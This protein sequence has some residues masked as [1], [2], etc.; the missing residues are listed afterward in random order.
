LC[1]EQSEEYRSSKFIVLSRVISHIS[2]GALLDSLLKEV[3][4]PSIYEQ[5]TSVTE[6]ASGKTKPLREYGRAVLEISLGLQC[7]GLIAKQKGRSFRRYLIHH[8]VPL[9][10]MLS[11]GNRR[12]SDQAWSSLLT[13]AGTFQYGDVNQLLLENVDYIVDSIARRIRMMDPSAPS[14]LL[15][16]MTVLKTKGIVYLVDCVDD[17]TL[18]LADPSIDDATLL[19]TIR[20]LK[21]LVDLASELFQVEWDKKQESAPEGLSTNF[22]GDKATEEEMDVELMRLALE[23]EFATRIPDE[24]WDAASENMKRLTLKLFREEL[25]GQEADGDRPKKSIEEIREY[26]MNSES[27]P[28]TEHQIHSTEEKPIPMEC[29]PLIRL[30]ESALEG[31]KHFLTSENPDIRL[32][33]LQTIGSS[34]VVLAREMHFIL[35]FL[36]NNWLSLVSRLHDPEIFVLLEAIPLFN[37][38]M[39]LCGDFLARKF[40]DFLLPEYAALLSR[41][42][43][44]NMAE[45]KKP[46]YRFSVGFRVQDAI[47]RSIHVAARSKCIF[48]ELLEKQILPLIL[49]LIDIQRQ[50]QGIYEQVQSLV[51]LLAELYPEKVAA[52]IRGESSVVEC[53]SWLK[54]VTNVDLP[55]K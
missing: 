52:Y 24:I 39:E 2:D 19:V 17:L 50:N 14:L 23:N 28:E 42:R 32:L 38:S 55:G 30:T 20:S 10:A 22:H 43:N 27:Q 16:V 25:E 51:R 46:R 11:H 41:Y 1:L 54:T 40:Q 21:R 8:L 7:V 26:F 37:R 49:P 12:I 34:L 44:T 53:N 36:N 29:Q 4:D 15:A 6:D 13:V 3:T 45:T 9:L 47:L 31:S 48:P 35:A 33:V 18:W 5:P